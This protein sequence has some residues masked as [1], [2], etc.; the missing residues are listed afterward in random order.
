MVDGRMGGT[1]W[2]DLMR[3][4]NPRE[5]GDAVNL[6]AL[7]SLQKQAD[8]CEVYDPDCSC[9]GCES[10]TALATHVLPL[11]EAL[12]ASDECVMIENH[13]DCLRCAALKALQEALE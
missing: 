8:T 13:D 10:L 1:E 11:A 4:E 3:G 6:D 2:G 5:D 7:R 12:V 9:A